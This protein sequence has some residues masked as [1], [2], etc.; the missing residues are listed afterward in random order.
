MRRVKEVIVVEGR[1][2]QNALRQVVDATVLCTD[3]FAIFREK[4]RQTLL[5]RLAQQRGLII[6][7]D[8]DGA[9]GLIRSFLCGIVD[10]KYVKHA[11]VPD[12]PGKEKRKSSPSR[13]GK[14][15][16][17]GM[18][19]AVLL[20]AL[21]L[22]GA[23]FD[24]VESPRWSEP[25]TRADLYRW[26][27]SGGAASREKRRQLQ[28]ALALPER[29][30]SGQLLQVLNILSSRGELEQLMV[31]GESTNSDPEE[32][33]SPDSPAAAPRPALPTEE[34]PDAAGTG[35]LTR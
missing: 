17:E 26:G 20:R 9:G 33:P 29:M 31:S 1:Y 15:G 22:A 21:E 8:P 32:R 3:G 34:L 18:R 4:E 13:E 7:T 12:I 25:I 30:S 10:P 6:L 28:K 16:V 23:T 5:R 14:L 19:P 24:G 2:D 27:L 35:S 11:Y